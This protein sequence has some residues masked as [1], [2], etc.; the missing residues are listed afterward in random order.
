M[1]PKIA[2]HIARSN[3]PLFSSGDRRAMESFSRM[4]A[5]I[6]SSIFPERGFFHS[7]AS[8]PSLYDP[9]SSD[10]AKARIIEGYLQKLASATGAEQRR[11]LISK[12][13]ELNAPLAQIAES[14][15]GRALVEVIKHRPEKTEEALSVLSEKKDTAS[16][17]ML[18]TE[19]APECRELAKGHL[20]FAIVSVLRHAGVKMQGEKNEGADELRNANIM[21]RRN[22]ENLRD[23][24]DLRDANIVP[25]LQMVASSEDQQNALGAV[26]L[27]YIIDALTA[28]SSI[29][30]GSSTTI[31]NEAFSEKASLE[32]VD[33]LCSVLKAEKS[34]TKKLQVVGALP[35]IFKKTRHLAVRDHLSKT[36]PIA[37]FE[38]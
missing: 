8:K 20:A 7:G 33:Y 9:P 28:L 29:A 32:A 25:A 13:A 15:G 23:L 2:Q 3:F 34:P 35:L 36:F 21:L 24:P 10:G 31:A 17:F 30:Q 22:A 37:K 38:R 19:C 4:E 14:G 27:L 6:T 12:L 16:M 11:E 18:A 5:K 1:S 26:R